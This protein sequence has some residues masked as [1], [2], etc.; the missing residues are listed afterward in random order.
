VSQPL[1]VTTLDEH[2][3]TILKNTGYGVFFEGNEVPVLNGATELLGR[4][5]RAFVLFEFSIAWRNNNHMLREA[6][7]LLDTKECSLFRILP[8][9]LEHLRFYTPEMDQAGCCNYFA[10]KGFDL[11]EVKVPVPSTTHGVNDIYLFG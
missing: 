6:C 3:T 4:L 5:K 7:H 11:S 2:A 10:V 9:G 8:F 1:Q